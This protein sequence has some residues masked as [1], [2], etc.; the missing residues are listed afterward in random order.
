MR[1]FF[2]LTSCAPAIV[3]AMQ[4]MNEDSLASVSGQ[5][6]IV[7]E[8][9]PE[10]VDGRLLS[11]GE[12]RFT[13]HDRDGLGEDY[14]SIAGAS[15]YMT[16]PD[17]VGGVMADTIRTSIDV[18]AAGDVSIRTTDISNL[19]L[20]VGEIS[21]SGRSVFSGVRLSDWF[22]AGNSYLETLLVN[23]PLGAKVGMRTIM[24]PGSGL[25]YQFDE[26]AVTFSG[27]VAFMPSSGNSQFISELFLSGDSDNLKLEFGETQG[28][29]EINN[30][31]L[32]D[33]AGNPLFGNADFGDVGYGDVNISQGYI[34]L[35][36]SDAPGV[37]G[38]KGHLAADLTIGSAFYRTGGERINLRN[39]TLRTNGELSYTLDFIDN[40]FATGIEAQI[41]DVSDLDL[42]IGG[43]T[44]SS[45]DGSDESI[46]MGAYGIE[47][48]N[49]NG[50]SI[51]VGLYTLPG[52]GR[53]GL[54]LDLA[55]SGKTEFDLTIKDSPVDNPFDPSAP[56]L[57][58]RVV[59]QNV[60]IAQTID[61][62]EKGLHIGV[63]D[64]SLDASI[65]QIKIGT[66][67]NYQGQTGRL[68][69]NNLTIQP[70]SY[71]RVEPIPSP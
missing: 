65:N 42:I 71:F 58:A 38:I 43:L 69:M 11:T 26:D 54:R 10:S 12:I 19:S 17:G 60:S 28:S 6:G 49:L 44:L 32:L 25:L 34:T 33:Q 24:E 35:A 53:Q 66:G 70:G 3:C 15:L 55:M 31:T 18:T 45:G 13:E 1:Y 16:Q 9:T 7:I 61:Q 51:E 4:P 22:F 20:A 2:L 64:T 30:I 68:V 29:L 59:L 67:E 14:L 23:D 52:H 48:V 47:N 46:S 40:G 41:T 50:G 63:I 56:A 8:T 5:A 57:T 27:Q 62:T 36:A 39:V 21:L 37:D